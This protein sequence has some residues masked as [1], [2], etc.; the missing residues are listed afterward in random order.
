MEADSRPRDDPQPNTLSVTSISALDSTASSTR[1]GLEREQT[2]NE[3]SPPKQG[4]RSREMDEK[5]VSNVKMTTKQRQ[6]DAKEE[7]YNEHVS[8]SVSPKDL[9]IVSPSATPVPW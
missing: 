3:G 5:Q 6:P 7:T 4:S 2:E 1:V 8:R 9:I